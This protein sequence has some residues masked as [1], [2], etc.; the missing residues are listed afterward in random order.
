MGSGNKPDRHEVKSQ[1]MHSLSSSS[2]AG[3]LFKAKST[4]F[5]NAKTMGKLFK[6]NCEFFR[7]KIIKKIAKY[8]FSISKNLKLSDTL[9][10]NWTT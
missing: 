8:Y 4:D 3:N 1:K 5:Q 10:T 2:A 7:S 9:F 6:E